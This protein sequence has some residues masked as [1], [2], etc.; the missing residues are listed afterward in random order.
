MHSFA[1]EATGRLQQFMPCPLLRLGASPDAAPGPADAAVV[2]QIE[3]CC[4]LDPQDNMLVSLPA[5]MQ[6]SK[7]DVCL[8]SSLVKIWGPA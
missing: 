8:V 6:L 3:A 7:T 5:A 2:S 1:G 4:P